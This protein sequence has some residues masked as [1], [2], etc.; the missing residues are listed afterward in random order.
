MPDGDKP[1]PPERSS[2]DESLQQERDKTDAELAARSGATEVAATEAITEA[3]DKADSVLS[4]ARARED[5][6]NADEMS[7]Q[8]FHD[9]SRARAHEDAALQV[10][11]SG[12]DAAVRGESEQRRVALAS[13]LAFERDDTDM[14][15]EL[16]RERADEALT[17]REDFMA[18]VSHDLRSLLGG[19]ALSAELLRNLDPTDEPLV[20]VTKYAEKIQRFS[21]RM[22]RLVGDLMDVASI[23]SGKLAMVPSRCEAG[24]VLREAVDAFH[25]AA[26]ARG[27]ELVGEMLTDPGPHQFDHD[28]ILQVLTNLVGNALQ[29]TPKGG[30]ITLRVDLGD[31]AARFSV[32]DTGKGIPTELLEKIFERHVQLAPGE[33]RGLGLGL[34]I[35]RS[36]V[37]AH[38]GWIWAKS[39][40]GVGSTF[41]F[42]LPLSAAP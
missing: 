33:R 21:A 2:T 40:V 30:R 27:I 6:R 41:V 13:L 3:R 22:S 38:G 20:K 19:I 8:S 39:T 11:R 31:G 37:E 28:R 1:D 42:T 12:A 15:L 16:E 5:V 24:L 25:P 29:F 35:S 7:A 34:F 32:E 17:T 10:A 14:R 26:V 18:M 23:E 4:D 9:L 36:I